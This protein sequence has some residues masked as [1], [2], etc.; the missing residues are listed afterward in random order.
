[1]GRDRDRRKVKDMLMQI[2]ST[3]AYGNIGLKTNDWKLTGK[4]WFARW[5]NHPVEKYVAMLV[6]LE[7]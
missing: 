4:L 5:L 1:M 7:I 3:M 6:E 2:L